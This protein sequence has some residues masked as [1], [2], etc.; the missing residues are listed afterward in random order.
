L[1]ED[2]CMAQKLAHF[3][4]GRAYR[5][6]ERRGPVRSSVVY[7]RLLIRKKDFDRINVARPAGVEER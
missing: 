6:M 4:L 5:K 3:Q 1:G 7:R 2:P